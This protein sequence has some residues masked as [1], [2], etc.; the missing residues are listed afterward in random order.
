MNHYHSLWNN[1]VIQHKNFLSLRQFYPETLSSVKCKCFINK[2]TL[3]Q[4][5]KKIAINISKLDSLGI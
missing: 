3:R 1:P 2:L 4:A 5:Y